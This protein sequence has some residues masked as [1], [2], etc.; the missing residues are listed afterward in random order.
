[1]NSEDQA[2]ATPENELKTNFIAEVDLADLTG[3][4]LWVSLDSSVETECAGD[5]RSSMIR[6]VVRQ[7]GSNPR[8]DW[9][10]E[11]I[12]LGAPE[13][14]AL[15]IDIVETLESQQKHGLVL[16]DLDANGRR[17][18]AMNGRALHPW[19]SLDLALRGFYIDVQEVVT[20]SNIGQMHDGRCGCAGVARDLD[21]VHFPLGSFLE[22]VPA[23][24]ASCHY[25]GAYEASK[26]HSECST[27]CIARAL[28]LAGFRREAGAHGDLEEGEEGEEGGE[29][30]GGLGGW[31]EDR[32]GIRIL[33]T[34]PALSGRDG[35]RPAEK[36]LLHQISLDKARVYVFSGYSGHEWFKC[37]I[38]M[39]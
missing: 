16:L 35:R 31:V 4:D 21:L 12:G 15:F 32:T 34:I 39:G 22:V 37:L 11:L 1:M 6:L 8:E 27:H 19:M 7:I 3:S 5:D 2:G 38:K 10:V 28:A 29:E 9:I 25:T 14:S 17:I 26:D 13:W 36:R 33:Y 30:E 18:V 23:E 24:A 20:L